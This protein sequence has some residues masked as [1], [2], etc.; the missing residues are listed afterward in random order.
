[1]R[2]KILAIGAEM[3][4]GQY[5]F[6]KT[7]V[8]QHGHLLQHLTWANA[9]AASARERYDAERAKKVAAF[10]YLEKGARLSTEHFGANRA[11]PACC[12]QLV[13]EDAL[14]RRKF[15]AHRPNY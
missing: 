5:H 15:T 7:A 3:D 9:A 11:N 13:D 12:P 10:L 14:A 2:S 4:A 8:G 1:C 6:A